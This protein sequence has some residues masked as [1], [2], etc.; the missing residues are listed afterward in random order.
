[1]KVSTKIWLCKSTSKQNVPSR[2]MHFQKAKLK[3][4]AILFFIAHNNLVLHASQITKHFV[5]LDY[6]V[7]PR[8]HRF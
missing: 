8:I 6:D 4:F 5:L 3:H 1:M 2:L 7:N